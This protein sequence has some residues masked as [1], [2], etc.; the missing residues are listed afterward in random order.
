MIGKAGMLSRRSFFPYVTLLLPFDG[1][2]GSTT[3]TDES[4]N[5]LTVT[6]AG[7]AAIS[8]SESKFGGAS[9]YFGGSGDHLDTSITSAGTF[10]LNDFTVECWVY[11][12]S[13]SAISIAEQS[14]FASPLWYFYASSNIVVFGV[15]GGGP[16]SRFPNTLSSN[17]WHHLAVCR[18]SGVVHMFLDG[19]KQSVSNISGGIGSYDF[20]A[21]RAIRIGRIGQVPYTGFIDDFRI[22]KAARYTSN[23]TVPTSAF[24]TS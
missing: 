21:E 9:V 8:T 13:S 12:P 24:P 14:P 19:V 23:F 16:S 3:F 4:S 2:N 15:H 11:A 7:N 22:T 20:S 18:K 6:A 5:N 1:S 17:T 10:G